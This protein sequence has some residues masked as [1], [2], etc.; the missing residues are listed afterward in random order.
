ML[1]V[2]VAFIMLAPAYWI[3]LFA[4]LGFAGTTAVIANAALAKGAIGTILSAVSLLPAANGKNG[5][6]QIYE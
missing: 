1:A 4:G 6:R 3:G 5:V 2:P